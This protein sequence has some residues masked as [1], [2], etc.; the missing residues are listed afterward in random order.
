M[1]RWLKDESYTPPV[2]FLSRPDCTA[3][4]NLAE[5]DGLLQDTWHPKKRKYE[6]DPKRTGGLPPPVR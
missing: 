2:T 1:H 6:T 3:T 5:M 4:A